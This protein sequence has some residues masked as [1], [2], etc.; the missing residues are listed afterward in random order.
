MDISP[1]CRVE[2]LAVRKRY[3][4]KEYIKLDCFQRKR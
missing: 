4:I 3:D 2:V 1:N